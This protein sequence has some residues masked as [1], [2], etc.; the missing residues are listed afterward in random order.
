[1]TIN[2]RRHSGISGVVQEWEPRSVKGYAEM[3]RYYFVRF[4]GLGDHPQ[5]CD[6]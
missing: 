4:E 3:N 2:A 5:L 1:M 6:G